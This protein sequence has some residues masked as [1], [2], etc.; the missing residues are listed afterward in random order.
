VEIP[1]AL[2]PHSI[3]PY[4]YLMLIG[5]VVG[6]YGH[7]AK[8]QITVAIGI[9]LIFVATLLLPLVVISTQSTPDTGGTKIYPPGTRSPVP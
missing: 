3:S 9:G 7:M 6:A 1:L 2:L 4:L 8:S 5:F